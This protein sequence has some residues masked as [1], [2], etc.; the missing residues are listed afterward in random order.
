MVIKILKGLENEVRQKYKANIRGV[1]GSFVRG[2]QDAKS[3]I[4]I[5]VEFEEGA[6]LFDFVGLS[7]FL[8]ERFRFPVDIVPIDTIREE[9]KENI[10]KEAIFL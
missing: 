2:D 9:I 7:I 3:D 5:L 6:N 10:L 4:D 1:F 8:E